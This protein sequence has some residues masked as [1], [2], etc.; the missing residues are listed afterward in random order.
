MKK[1]ADTHRTEREFTEGVWVYLR[2]QPYRQVSVAGRKP[3]KLSPLFYG[4]YKV[5][6]RIGKVAYKLALSEESKIHPVLH[7][8]QLKKKLGTATVVQHQV[9]YISVEQLIESELILN[10]RMGKQGNQAIVEVLIKWK[11]LPE[12]EVAWEPYR[13]LIR[14]FPNFKL[15]SRPFSGEKN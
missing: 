5:M 12:K 11:F 7:V 10:C 15:E 1:L 8:S 13:D 4:S 2:L 6:K 14:R 3:H 9:P